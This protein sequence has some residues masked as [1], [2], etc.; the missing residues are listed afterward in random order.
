MNELNEVRINGFVYYADLNK[1]V[2][3]VDKERTSYTQFS[4]LT[5]N[6]RSQLMNEIFYPRANRY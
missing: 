5:S 3:Y 6:E 4:F 1:R 2:L